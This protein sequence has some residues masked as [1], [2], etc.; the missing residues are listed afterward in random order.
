MKE[1]KNKQI[2]QILLNDKNYE[3]FINSK[4]EKEFEDILNSKTEK[5]TVITN[6]KEV[7]RELL[8]SKHAVYMV[9]NKQSK[10]KSYINGIQADGYLGNQSIT[11][12]KLLSYLSDSFVSGN[13]FIKFYQIKF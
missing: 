8:L 9:I 11:R 4:T 6:I 5:E 1:D 12:E 7:P 13:N 10:T 3:N 2:E